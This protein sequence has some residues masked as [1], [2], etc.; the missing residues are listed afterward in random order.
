MRFKNIWKGLI[1]LMGY[2][3]KTK[4][5]NDDVSMV[6]HVRWQSGQQTIGP[7]G[8]EGMN[9]VAVLKGVN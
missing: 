9:G 2:G 3:I 7:S 8:Y 6:R 5:E 4:V 1:L